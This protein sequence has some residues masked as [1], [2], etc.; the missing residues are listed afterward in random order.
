MTVSAQ[1]TSGIQGR[2]KNRR[3]DF[4][5]AVFIRLR[6]RLVRHTRGQVVNEYVI[7]LG[8]IVLVFV[9]IT[10]FMALAE[11]ESSD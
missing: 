11:R 3:M 4:V 8:A 6:E 10:L 5:T 2:E 7:V 1:E 9:I